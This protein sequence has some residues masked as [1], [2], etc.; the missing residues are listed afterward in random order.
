V[1]VEKPRVAAPRRPRPPRRDAPLWTCPKCGVKL[2]TKNL[3]HSCGRATLADWFAKMT[4]RTRRLYDG[5]E[6]LIARCGDYH[7][8]PAKTRV[9]F[10]GRVRFAGITRISD[11]GMTCS[12][13]MPFPLASRRFV[14]VEEVVPGWW[15]HRLLVTDPCQLDDELLAWLRESYR[16]MGLQE[17]FDDE[18]SKMAAG[19]RRPRGRR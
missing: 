5:F 9:T 18:R 6:Q 1:A 16:L 19:R 4:P 7:V 2:L 3:A 11:K 15:S 14:R 8:S 12:F 17:R 13:A 10:L